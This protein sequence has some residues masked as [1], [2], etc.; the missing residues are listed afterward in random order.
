MS[1][2]AKNDEVIEYGTRIGIATQDISKGDYVHTHNIRS[3]RWSF[4]ES[5]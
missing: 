5:E 1:D 3:A 2:I 4:E